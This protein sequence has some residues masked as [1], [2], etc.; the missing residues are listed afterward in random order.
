[1]QQKLVQLEQQMSLLTA[2]EFLSLQS[3]NFSSNCNVA[4]RPR[5]LG[6]PCT[7]LLFVVFKIWVTAFKKIS[8]LLISPFTF[9]ILG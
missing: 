1:M 2:V 9:T 3:T 7:R 6:P 5:S 4:L 8:K